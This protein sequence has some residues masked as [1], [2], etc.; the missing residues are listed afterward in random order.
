MPGH[1]QSSATVSGMRLAELSEHSGVP[2]SSIK[3]YLRER[4]LPEGERVNRTTAEYSTVHVQRLALV[5]AL[6]NVGGLSLDQCRAVLATIDAEPTP[7]LTSVL[8]AVFSGP[9][10]GSVDGTA[11]RELVAE[12]GW[13]VDTEGPAMTRLA[14]G[15]AA[16]TD[17]GLGLARDQLRELADRVS[18]VA[19]YEIDTV[20][21]DSPESAVR[22]AVL[23]TVL[24]APVLLALRELAHQDQA[25]RRFGAAGDAG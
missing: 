19:A 8:H 9:T 4:L 5:K 10:S 23:G 21:T 2:I 3:Y 18:A 20:P 22:W 14:V 16:S 15:L 17:A 6:L 11:A 25:V 13:Q 7:P 24:N 12:L 1:E